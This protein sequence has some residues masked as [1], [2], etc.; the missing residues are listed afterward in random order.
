MERAGLPTTVMSGAEDGGTLAP[1]MASLSL[2]LIA[3]F[4]LFYS[5][6][7]IDEHKKMIAVGSLQGSFGQLDGGREVRFEDSLQAGL[8]TS[9]LV[10]ERVARLQRKL[11]DYM[12]RRGLKSSEIKVFAAENGVEIALPHK[13]L[14]PVGSKSLSPAG[15]NLMLKV[16]GL[17]NGLREVRYELFDYT[18]VKPANTDLAG[19]T[20]A[21]LRATALYRF[22]VIRGGFRAETMRAFGRQVPSTAGQSKQP[23]AGHVLLKVI[24]GTPLY[25]LEGNKG[26]IKIGDFTFE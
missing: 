12:Q 17:L 5:M 25:D 2:I 26:K 18:T 7:V 3:F 13:Y 6:T 10:Q 21:S 16:A 14:F 1:L 8:M 11:W 9:T 15:A 4:I 23:A 24:G 22:L 20:L 19:L